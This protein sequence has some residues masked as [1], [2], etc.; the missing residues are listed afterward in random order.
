MAR[1][2]LYRPQPDTL[3]YRLARGARHHRRPP[4][5]YPVNGHQKGS[6]Q[7]V[8]QDLQHCG[9][10][11]RGHFGVAGHRRGRVRRDPGLSCLFRLVQLS[12]RS[13]PGCLLSSVKQAFDAGP[14]RAHVSRCPF[15]D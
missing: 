12:R 7:R 13:R 11:P 5:V 10:G 9:G 15:L 8:R 4:A 14:Q 2:N 3:F 6:G 1:F